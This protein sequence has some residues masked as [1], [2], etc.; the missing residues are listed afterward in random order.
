MTY[1]SNGQVVQLQVNIQVG[2]KDKEWLEKNHSEIDE[3]FKKS[4]QEIDPD[5]FRSKKG[6]E[7][8]LKKLKDDINSKMNVNKVEAVLYK[9]ML[10]QHQVE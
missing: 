3:I 6:N 10:I 1:E 4:V 9:D 7:D 5:L 8:V 2:D